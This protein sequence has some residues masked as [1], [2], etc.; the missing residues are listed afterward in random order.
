[1]AKRRDFNATLKQLTDVYAMHLQ[2]RMTE[3]VV[4]DRLL[5]YRTMP[6]FDRRGC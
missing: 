2:T 5:Y 3:G 6:F 1:V 4:W